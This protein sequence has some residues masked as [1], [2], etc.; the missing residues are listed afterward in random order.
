M[1]ELKFGDIIVYNGNSAFAQFTNINREGYRELYIALDATTGMDSLGTQEETGWLT[2]CP[3][4]DYTIYSKSDDLWEHFFNIFRE[5]LAD[6]KA[7]TVDAV[8]T[9]ERYLDLLHPMRVK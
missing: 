2:N 5:E 4:G 7:Q 6:W 8:K 3:E 1:K 9:A